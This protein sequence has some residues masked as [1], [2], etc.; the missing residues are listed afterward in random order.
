MIMEI[1][2]SFIMECLHCRT[3]YMLGQPKQCNCD[4]ELRAKLRAEYEAAGIVHNKDEDCTVDPVTHLCV[5]CGVDHSDK[6]LICGGRGFHTEA[7]PEGA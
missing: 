7:C 5:I 6:C 4:Q 1:E 3:P 2:G